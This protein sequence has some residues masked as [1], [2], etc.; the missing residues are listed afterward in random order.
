MLDEKEDGLSLL[1]KTI[2]NRGHGIALIDIGIGTGA[3]QSALKADITNEELA[4][5]EGTTAA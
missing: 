2:E 3:I 5:T 1:K 4:R